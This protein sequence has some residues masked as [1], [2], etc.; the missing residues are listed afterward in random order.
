[1]DL[2]LKNVQFTGNL[3]P[4]RI[5]ALMQ[6]SDALVLF[7]HFDGMPVVALEALSCGLPV[8][9]TKVG[10]LPFIIKEEF[11]LMCDAGD[12]HEMLQVLEDF[13]EGKYKF[14]PEAMR[15]F[16][17]QYASYDAVGK[18]MNDLYKEIIASTSNAK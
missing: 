17:L 5:A 11:G 16:I 6:Q 15:Q 4:E 8:L 18:Q 13:F 12:E 1:M 2:H 7:S 14:N 10:Q 9:A 3:A